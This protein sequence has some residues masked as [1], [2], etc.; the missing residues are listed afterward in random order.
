MRKAVCIGIEYRE[1]AETFPTLHLP[2]AHMDPTIMAELL[3][4]ESWCGRFQRKVTRAQLRG[5]RYATSRSIRVP[6]REYSNPYRREGF[7][8]AT[9]E[10]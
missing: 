1:L 3:Q 8:Y 4:G 10:R 7:Q 5:V 9:N 2:A 6:A